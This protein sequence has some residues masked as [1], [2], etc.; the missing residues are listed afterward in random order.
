MYFA[1][2]LIFTNFP[3]LAKSEISDRD[4]KSICFKAAFEMKFKKILF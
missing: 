2:S 1:F 4:V 3:K